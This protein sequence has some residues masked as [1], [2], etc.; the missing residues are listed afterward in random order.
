[1][2]RWNPNK[3]QLLCRDVQHAWKPSTAWR[4]GRKYV[5]VFVCA[6]CTSQKIQTLDKDGYIIKSKMT[7]PEGYLRPEGR[8]TRADRAKLRLRNYDA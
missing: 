8:M 4:E 7:Y 3:A 6:R 1:M 5:R 2:K